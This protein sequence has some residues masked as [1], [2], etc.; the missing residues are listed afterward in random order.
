MPASK[1]DEY[2]GKVYVNNQGLKMRIIEYK[3]ANDVTVEFEDGALRKAALINLK[4]GCVRHPNNLRK[5]SDEYLGKVF[6]NNQ[7]LKM[8]VI[9]Y[10]NNN[11]VTVEFEDGALRKAA[12][13][14]L[15]NGCVR[16]PNNL[17]KTSDEY[18]GKVF[19]NNQGLK[20]KVIEYKNNS[21]VTVVFEDGVIRKVGLSNLKNGSV[22]H[23]NNL[24]KTNDEYL[25]KVYTNNQ[26]L[27]MRIIEYKN[28]HDVTVEFE[29]GATRKTRIAAVIVGSVRH[30][31]NKRKS[32]EDYLGNVYLN[33]KGFKMKVV[34]YNG[35][36]NVVVRFDN[37]YEVRT[38][39]QHVLAGNVKRRS[40]L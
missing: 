33:N 7:G 26:G 27:K 17:R 24:R 10:K 2:L 5:T 39:M 18:L 16:H 40:L 13:I 37:G 35:K 6:V 1:R 22:R 32:E 31:S 36:N 9:E 28:A 8:K 14:N 21:D 38:T 12:L 29:D 15:K 19:V 23:P 25:G 3:N 30:P 34:E 20:M 11:D 4:N